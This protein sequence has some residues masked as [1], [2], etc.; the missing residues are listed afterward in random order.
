MYNEQPPRVPTIEEINQEK[1]CLIGQY[2]PVLD[3]GHTARYLGDLS[4]STVSKLKTGSF[5]SLA[6]DIVFSPGI[7]PKT[8]EPAF[9][10]A[11]KELLEPVCAGPLFDEDDLFVKQREEDFYYDQKSGAND[12]K[13]LEEWVGNLRA[14]YLML[15]H[16][17]PVENAASLIQ[18]NLIESALC[19]MAENG[20][21]WPDNLF[22]A[23][24][25][26]MQE[27]LATLRKE[28]EREI[29]RGR[30]LAPGQFFHMANQLEFRER[31]FLRK[32]IEARA[33][34]VIAQI[35]GH[36]TLLPPEPDHGLIFDAGLDWQ[37]LTGRQ[38]RQI[39]LSALLH[40]HQQADV[41]TRLLL[42]N[43]DRPVK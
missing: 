32:S 34:M 28:I 38:F 35:T 27:R 43:P 20:E 6:F 24:P 30:T 8:R 17:R 13:F 9:K 36:Q 2:I 39:N 5:G 19:R 23:L 16:F 25:Y 40:N 7:I 22:Y 3:T 33:E 41:W 31:E 15:R 29:S 37:H 1:A 10:R 18:S 11:Y 26:P 4:E 12:D 42:G 21:Y 14:V